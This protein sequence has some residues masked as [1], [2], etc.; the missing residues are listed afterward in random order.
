MPFIF[1][2]AN[3]ERRFANDCTKRSISLT[4]GMPYREV[5]DGLNAQKRLTG[6]RFFYQSPNPESYVRDVLGLKRIEMPRGERVILRDFALSHPRGRYIV[7]LPE[8]WSAC[9]DGIIYDTWDCSGED[10]LAFYEVKSFKKVKIQ[11]KFCYNVN[12]SLQNTLKI[13]VIDGNGQRSTKEF[14]E[15]SA[16]QY[17]ARLQAMSLFNSGEIGEYI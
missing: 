16:T 5:E 11:R 13:T 3:P 17:I 7:S 12:K 14:N 6:V 4:T 15:K 8:H 2:N 9:I 10:V 1:Y